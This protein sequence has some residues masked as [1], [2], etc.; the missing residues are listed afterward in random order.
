[1][2]GKEGL[3]SESCGH[4]LVY[5]HRGNLSPTSGWGNGLHKHH[6]GDLDKWSLDGGHR[7]MVS[8]SLMRNTKNRP[9][10][11]GSGGEGQY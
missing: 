11:S 8:D 1:M 7:T 2:T 10:F 5:S 9:P 3:F 6:F 4:G